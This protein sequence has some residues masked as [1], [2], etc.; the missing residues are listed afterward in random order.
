MAP[1]REY[2][3]A[4]HVHTRFSDGEAG[5]AEIGAVA[6]DAGVDVVFVSDHGTLNAKR[7]GWEGR[8]AGVLVVVGA[9]VG[10]HHTRH[11]HAFRVRH[12]CNY[13]YLPDDG[14]LNDVAA[15]GGFAVAAH[16]TGLVR[17][18]PRIHHPPWTRWEHPTLRGFE[19][20]SY[21]HDWVRSLRL[22]D[23][24]TPREAL[25]RPEGIVRGPA[26]GLLRTWDRVTRFGRL[27]AVGGVD[28]HGRSAPSIGIDIMPHAQMFRALRTHLF[29]PP[30]RGDDS[31]VDLALDAVA[32]GRCFIAHDALGDSVGLRA[33]AETP[34]G[35]V[36]EMG[37][38]RVFGGP[39]WLRLRLP[40]VAE[41]RLIRNGR[42]RLRRETDRFEFRALREG[43]YRFEA[44]LQG[45]PWVFTNPF[46]LRGEG[47]RAQ[48]RPT[49]N[50]MGRGRG[51]GAGTC[52]S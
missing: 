21:P 14:F 9:E 30:W 20:W 5:P 48:E 24:L 41:V 12:C 16:P 15:Q 19:L 25:F 27:A 46:Y 52:R 36:I 29:T 6:R 34:V 35:D 40:R 13:A 45:R 17:R 39:T 33:E 51:E 26:R 47:V 32:E 11:C 49:A 18:L 50:G 4:F 2:V 22:L 28:S 8:R 37:E 44:R 42:L 1:L 10:K 38:E 7:E 43:V 23:L 3:A 31:D